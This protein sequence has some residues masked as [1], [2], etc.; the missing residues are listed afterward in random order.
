MNLSDMVCWSALER[1]DPN[2]FCRYEKAAFA[3]GEFTHSA[4]LLLE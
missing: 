2:G 3:L 4:G 1:G